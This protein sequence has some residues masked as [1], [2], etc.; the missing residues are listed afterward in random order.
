MKFNLEET[1]TGADLKPGATLLFFP[2]ERLSKILKTLGEQKV[3]IDAFFIRETKGIMAIF[4]LDEIPNLPELLDCDSIEPNAFRLTLHG[5][6]LTEGKGLAALWES[7]LL[8]QN[9]PP[10]LSASNCSGI[11]HYFPESARKTVLELLDRT[12][13]IRAV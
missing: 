11:T 8:D 2:R 6:R 9:I 1:I 12:F 7:V 5:H 4:P 3:S 13:G 10:V